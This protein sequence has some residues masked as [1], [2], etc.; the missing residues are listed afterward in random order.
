[1]FFGGFS[2]NYLLPT[3]PATAMER[4]ALASPLLPEHHLL[5]KPMKLSVKTVAT[6]TLPRGKTDAIHFDAEMAGFG[7]RLRASGGK[8]RRS[9]IVQYRRVGATRRV[10]LGSAEVLS[11]EQARTAAKKILAKVA[12]GEDPQ[13]NKATRRLKDGHT[14]WATVEDYLETK[15]PPQTEKEKK[16][17]NRVRPRTYG[18]LKRYLRD[19]P[20]FKPLHATPVDC[21]TRK[22]VA[23]RLVAITR[24][25]GSIVAARARGALSTFYVWALGNGLA[26]VN[27]VVGTLKPKDAEPREHVLADDGLS[28]I[29]RASGDDD[30]GKVIKLLILTGARRAEVGGMRW[31]ELDLERGR[32]TI[33]AERSKNRRA[34]TLPLMPMALDIIRGVPPRVSR[35][36]LFGSRSADGLSHWHAKADLDRQLGEIVGPWRVHDIRR[37]VAT[38]M[39][40]LGVQPHVIEQILN[41]QSGHRAGPAGIYNRSSYER[42]VRAALAL[43]TDHVRAL[44]E[45]GE[46]KI[47]PL[48]GLAP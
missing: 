35:D 32:W 24:E 48:S 44:V 7:F 6:L 21:I 28:A 26:E 31:S 18:E 10:L 27:P 43:W 37:S 9:W 36:Q 2:G 3:M 34:H 30:Y 33:P 4:R 17:K 1:L 46:R 11:A 40:D 8:V 29:W 14:L 45:G 42:E 38:R 39:A 23:S 5:G 16:D 19:G 13:A 12:L 47:L 25:H 20:F 22:D 15:R 41:H